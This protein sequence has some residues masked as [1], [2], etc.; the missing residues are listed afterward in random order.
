MIAIEKPKAIITSNARIFL[1]EMFR[2]ALLINPTFSTVLHVNFES[3]Q[4]G[5]KGVFLGSFRAYGPFR[6][7][8]SL[9]GCL[10]VA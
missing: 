7:F 3:N 9:L 10:K 4:E 8:Q 1:R 5:T 6:N 2:I